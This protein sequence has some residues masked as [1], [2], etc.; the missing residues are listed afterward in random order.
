[1]AAKKSEHRGRLLG[2]AEFYSSLELEEGESLSELD[3]AAKQVAMG[4]LA[5]AAE[6]LY[7]IRA[8]LV[9]QEK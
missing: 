2:F 9:G 1:M 3:D 5:M 7:M 6:D 4:L 8:A